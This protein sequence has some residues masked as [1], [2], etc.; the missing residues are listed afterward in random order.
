MKTYFSNDD[1]VEHLGIS[2][3][4][5]ATKKPNL[6]DSFDLHQPKYP[7]H[8]RYYSDFEELEFLGKGGF[9]EV[10]KVRNKL[11]NRFYAIKRIKLKSFNQNLNKKLLR[12]VLAISRLHHENIIWRYLIGLGGMKQPDTYSM[13]NIPTNRS[14]LCLYIQM[15]FCPNKTLRDLIDDGLEVTEAWRLFRQIIEALVH[16]HGQGMIHRDLKP[17]NIFLDSKGDVKVGDFGLT[18]FDETCNNSESTVN[19]NTAEANYP[20]VSDISLTLG[21]FKLLLSLDVGTPFYQGPEL[22]ITGFKYNQRID[23]YSLGIIFFEMFHGPFETKMERAILL[24]ALRAP[25][26]CLPSEWEAKRTPDETN[27]LKLLLAHNPKVHADCS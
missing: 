7:S 20:L 25:E 16:I 19:S 18:F 6:T 27:L 24:N 17:S 13:G 8:S 3:T 22:A 5:L 10:V 1:L 14:S 21:T 26:I 12:E 2:R 11:D 23:M 4:L 15:E 9:G